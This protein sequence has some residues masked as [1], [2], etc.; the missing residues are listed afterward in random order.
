MKPFFK[1]FIFSSL[2]AVLVL[3]FAGAGTLMAHGVIWDYSAKPSYGIKFSYDDDTPMKYSEVKV[4]GPDDP[5]KLSQTGRTDIYGHFA[6]VPAEDGL[7]VLT[8][9]DNNGH[10]AR[11]ELTIKTEVPAEGAEAAP[12]Q[13]NVN[14][15]KVIG[16]ATKPLK[17]GLVVSIFLNLALAF[18]VF[19]KKKDA[20]PAGGQT[21]PSGDAP[22]PSQTPA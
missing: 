6:F 8:S 19:G 2:L 10:L 15:D 13:Q 14:L 18:K 17:I 4:Y 11:A 3:C 1:S 21:P 7:W 5:E 20:L 9:D 12:A 16:Q 22:P